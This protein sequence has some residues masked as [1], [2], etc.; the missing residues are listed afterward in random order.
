MFNT[1][2][3][4]TDATEDIL[5]RV[6]ELDED[7]E[8]YVLAS[9]PAVLSIGRRCTDHG[10]SF[11]WPSG[12]DPPYFV[13][14]QGKKVELVVVDDVPDLPTKRAEH[15]AMTTIPTNTKRGIIAI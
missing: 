3:G 11:T 12:S 15:I 2:N 5:L 7:I 9:T 8:P 6:D 13:S 1:A 4:N 10:Y 14:P